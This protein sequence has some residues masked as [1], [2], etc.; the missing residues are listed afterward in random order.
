LEVA[1]KKYLNSYLEVNPNITDAELKFI[2]ERTN[3]KK[4][5]KKEYF[6]ESGYIQNE[7]GFVFQG[8]LRSF[9]IDNKGKEITISFIREGNYASDYPSFIRQTPSKYYIQCIEPCIMVNLPYKSIKEA[10]NKFWNF[11][12]YGRLIAEAILIQKE[13]RIQS[14]QYDNAEERYLKFIKE[15]NELMNKVSISHLCSYLGI[16][17]QSLT[18]I[19]KKLLDI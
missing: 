10:Y 11:D 5:N 14:F 12:T 4:Y 6:L 1:I 9:Y 8:L 19:R 7:M 15:N 2:E 18:R 13:N 3:V 16:E 17:R